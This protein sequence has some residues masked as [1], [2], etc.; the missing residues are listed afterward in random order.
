MNHRQWKKRFKKIHGK[1]PSL[2]EDK[3]RLAKFKAKGI[4]QLILRYPEIVNQIAEAIPA[5]FERIAEALVE[6][7]NAL[8][9]AAENIAET[10]RRIWGNRE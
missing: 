9:R 7:S 4:Q 5:V 1:N 3:K 6:F 8:S 2:W 10:S